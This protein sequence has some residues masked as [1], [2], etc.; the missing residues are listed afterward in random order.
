MKNKAKCKLCESI[1]ESFHST[2]YV[3]CNCGEIAV[4]GGQS[5]KCY[6]K[7]FTNFLRVDDQGNEIVVTVKDSKPEPIPEDETI[8][9]KPTKQ[10]LVKH[11]EDFIK[12]LDN[13]P[14]QGQISPVTNQDLSSVLSV[15]LAVL[16][17]D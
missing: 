5:L 16:R 9:T 1:I 15:L 17:L 4:D 14:L 12:T 7:D 3:P 10:E 6:A 11:L 8:S 13:L 2:D